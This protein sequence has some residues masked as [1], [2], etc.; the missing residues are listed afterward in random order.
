MHKYT[1]TATYQVHE[2]W[3][4]EAILRP[5]FYSNWEK[6]LVSRANRKYFSFVFYM[7]RTAR[8]LLT[9][10]KSNI[11]RQ[12]LMKYC[13]LK[14]ISYFLICS[15]L[16]NRKGAHFFF[17]LFDNFFPGVYFYIH[18]INKNRNFFFSFCGKHRRK[19][20]FSML[21]NCSKEKKKI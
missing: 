19:C 20:V 21:L 14:W 16:R 15:L 9:L 4:N 17:G 18:Q 8:S 11:W 1:Y 12:Y 7:Q 5:K 2:Y 6:T 3:A 10:L 13:W